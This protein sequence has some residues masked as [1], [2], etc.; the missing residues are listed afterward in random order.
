MPPAAVLIG[1]GALSAAGSITQGI[2]ARKAG[3]AQAGEYEQQAEYEKGSAAA[4]INSNDYQ[5]G[6]LLA[7]S[8]ASASAGG[9]S[10]GGSTATVNSASAVQEKLKD[11]YTRYGGEAA[12]SEDLYEAANARWSGKQA[13]T[14]GIIKGASSLLTSVYQGNAA[15]GAMS[16]FLPG[17]P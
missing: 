5:A 1:A 10:E 14:A 7:K 8:R 6:K 4:Q 13:E 12:A 15:G 16:G 11:A 3:N 9:V 2:A 17:S